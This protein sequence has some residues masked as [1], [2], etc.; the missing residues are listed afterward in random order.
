MKNEQPYQPQD[1]RVLDMGNV[2]IQALREMGKPFPSIP[3]KDWELF[4]KYTGG[5]R[6]REFSIL[7]G[8]TGSGKTTW[9]A[10][11]S[12]QLLREQ[13]KHFVMSVETGHTDFMKR[14]CSALMR[15]DLN[16]GEVVPANVLSALSTQHM[17]LIQSRCIEFALYEDRL[18]SEQLCHDLRVMAKKGCK[19][20]I[21]DNLN[22]FMEVRRAQDAVYE[23]D[24][25]IHELIILCKQIDLHVMMVMHPRKTDD[26]TRVESEYDIKGSSTAVQEA[27]NIFLLNRP[28][29]ED[30]KSGHRHPHQRELKIAKMRR[31][32]K[33]VGK[34]ILFDCHDT[35]YTEKGVV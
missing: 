5:F 15:Q 16:T 34:A 27:H 30:L 32:G 10:N 31:R 1:P 14:V 4:N 17:H 18:P 26:G 22:F 12:A 29:L 35:W 6:P 2:F 20:A 25:V 24:R 21:I 23:M 13:V 33:F 3:V 11:L 7:C 19:L 28:R 9:L 8:S